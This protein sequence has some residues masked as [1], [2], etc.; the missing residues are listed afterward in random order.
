MAILIITEKTSQARDLR[1]ALGDRFGEILPAEG[2]VLRLA[3]PHE[4]EAS[5]RSWACALLKPKGLYPTQPATEGNKP[6]K[7]GSFGRWP[8]AEGDCGT[9]DDRRS[10]PRRAKVAWDGARSIIS[11]AQPTVRDNL[12]AAEP[13]PS[14]PRAAQPRRER[15]ASGPSALAPMPARWSNGRHGSGERPHASSGPPAPCG[16]PLVAGA[17]PASA[18]ARI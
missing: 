9:G 8:P 1:S 6:A 5:W 14:S 16:R 2:H 11:P 15:R 3:E 12:A 18:W 17:Q 4:V 7:G 10:D 13:I